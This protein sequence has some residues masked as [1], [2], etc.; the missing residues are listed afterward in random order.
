MKRKR[1]PWPIIAIPWNS[2]SDSSSYPL[3]RNSQSWLA[4]NTIGATI[5]VVVC[6]LTFSTSGIK[7]AATTDKIFAKEHNKL[8]LVNDI[9][10]M[11]PSSPIATE[12]EESKRRKGSKFW[13]ALSKSA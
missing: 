2:I 7:V 4:A 10:I 13:S 11:V 1:R 12:K 9:A 5:V 6:R 8:S 3:K